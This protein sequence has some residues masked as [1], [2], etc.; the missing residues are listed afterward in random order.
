MSSADPREIPCDAVRVGFI[1]DKTCEEPVAR[2]QHRVN[3][4]VNVMRCG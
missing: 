4:A 3:P 1:G 2:L